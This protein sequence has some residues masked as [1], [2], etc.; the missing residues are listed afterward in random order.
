MGEGV[1][2]AQRGN[3]FSLSRPTGE[4]RGE[5][6]FPLNPSKVTSFHRFCWTMRSGCRA[7]LTAVS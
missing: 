1:A 3:H 5:G 7:R 2:I 4:G 6:N